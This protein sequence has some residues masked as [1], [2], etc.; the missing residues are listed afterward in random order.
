MSADSNHSFIKSLWTGLLGMSHLTLQIRQFFSEKSP[1][2]MLSLFAQTYFAHNYLP[3]RYFADFQQ[4]TNA[5]FSESLAGQI[6]A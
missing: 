5:H 2:K 3:N 6:F 1:M 4:S